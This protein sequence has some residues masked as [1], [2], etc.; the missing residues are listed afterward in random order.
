MFFCRTS[1]THPKAAIIL[2]K[3]VVVMES[4]IAWRISSSVACDD[5]DLPFRQPIKET[6]IQ[7]LIPVVEDDNRYFVPTDK[8]SS[9]PLEDL[10]R[11]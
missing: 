9:R 7:T 11:Y 10:D 2:G 6:Y 5:S 3:P 8:N 1:S 4:R